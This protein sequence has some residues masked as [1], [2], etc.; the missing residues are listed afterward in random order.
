[1]QVESGDIS[2]KKWVIDSDGNGQVRSYV[3]DAINFIS[4]E[5][6]EAF[7]WTIVPYDYDAADTIILL[8]NDDQ[9]RKLIITDIYIQSDTATDF[10]IHSTDGAAFTPAGTAVEGVNLNRSLTTPALATCIAD[11]TANTQGN[12]IRTSRVAANEER[13]IE[14]KGAIVL[15]YG[16]VVAVDLVTDG[17]MCYATIEGYFEEDA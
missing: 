11:E 2:G 9:N 4:R 7:S 12:I 6:G 15:G 10:S 14:S 8:Q 1:M 3:Q 16:G 17:T 5:K 13:H